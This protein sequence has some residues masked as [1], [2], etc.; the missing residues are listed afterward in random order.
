MR[1]LSYA[2]LFVFALGLT[3]C[4]FIDAYRACKADEECWA[5]AEGR[6]KTAQTIVSTGVA[7]IPH[8]AAQ[9]AAPIAGKI[10]GF[11]MLFGSAI[12][13]GWALKGKKAETVTTP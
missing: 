2:L 5:K 9:G 6:Q 12:T 13:G 1:R 7:F 8:P 4:A 10:A 3:G 11:L